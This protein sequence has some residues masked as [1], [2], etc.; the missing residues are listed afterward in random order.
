MIKNEISQPITLI[1][2]KS[3]LSGTFPDKL[4]S[5]K[6]IPIH[7]KGNNTNIDNYRP[8]SILAGIPKI[9]EGVLFNQ[10]DEKIII[11]I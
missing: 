2:N 10:I 1:I 7:K 5:A 3:I 9:F 8:I 4:C 11:I 6:V